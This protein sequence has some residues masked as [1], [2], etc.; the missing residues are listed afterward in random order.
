MAD[1]DPIRS[2]HIAIAVAAFNMRL[3][4]R[5]DAS[6]ELQEV[7]RKQL[8]AALNGLERA[9]PQLFVRILTEDAAWINELQ[10][11]RK[12]PEASDHG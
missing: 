7:A 8:W 9:E 10:E 5:H 2:A 6:P 1:K 3:F 4:E 11:R 12:L